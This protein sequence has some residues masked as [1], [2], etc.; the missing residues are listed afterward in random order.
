MVNPLQRRPVRLVTVTATPPAAAVLAVLV[1]KSATVLAVTALSLTLV[2]T[3]TS[4][5]SI[6]ASLVESWVAAEALL[7]LL[8]MTLGRWETRLTLVADAVSRGTWTTR[9]SDS[10]RGPCA[11]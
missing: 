8:L 2:Y 10:G 5:S 6:L 1:S 11:L 3:E 4:K 9:L 7:L